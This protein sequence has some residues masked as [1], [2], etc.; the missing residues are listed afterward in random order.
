MQILAV[1]VGTSAIKGAVLDA[2]TAR[3]QGPIAHVPY[4]LSHPTP[5]AAEVSAAVLWDCCCRVARLACRDFPNVQ[6]VG[7][8]VL[9]PGLVL[10]DHADKPLGPIWTHLDR[11]SRPA[12]RQIWAAVG[13]E[14][15]ATTGN[16]PLPGG[17][18]AVCFRQMLQDDPYLSHRVRSY[19][20]VNGWLALCLTGTKA[21]DSGNASVTGLFGTLTNRQWSG[22]WCDFFEVDADWLP[23]IEQGNK[24]IGTLRAAVAGEWGLTAGIPVKLGMADTS[25]AVLDAGLTTDDLLHVVGTTQLIAKLVHCPQPS[26]RMLTRLLGVGDEYLQVMHNPVG[27][28]ALDWMRHLC[29]RDQCEEEFYERTVP[30]A[31]QHPTRVLLDPPF[32]G[33]DRLE[34]EAHRAALRDLTLS[35]DRLDLLAAVVQAMVKCHSEVLTVLGGSQRWKRIVLTGGGAE[36]VCRLVPEYA[37]LNVELV[38]EGSLCG[39]ARL[40]Q[41]G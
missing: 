38:E 21:F 5:E 31:M 15:L 39:V 4:E 14:L 27:G 36:T 1:D 9:T 3:H 28:V 17:V 23:A 35:A 8:S 11:R 25:C 2:A 40:F 24:T 10:L 13:A 19:L 34:I 20:H 26:P 29:F 22:R 32:L 7:L 30:A 37:K 6:G 41:T 16:R 18:S 33:G 12:A